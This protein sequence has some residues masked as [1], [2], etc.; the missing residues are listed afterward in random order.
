MVITSV[1]LNKLTTFP[2]LAPNDNKGLQE[3]E[4]LLL[5]LQCVKDDGGLAGLKILD[6]PAFL[7]PVLVKLAE[8]LQGR[9]QRHAYRFKSQHGVD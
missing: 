4:D 5:E 7:K 1:H 8:E 6:E 3:L 9:W 2:A